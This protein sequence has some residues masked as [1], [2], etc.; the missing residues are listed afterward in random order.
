M[1]TPPRRTPHVAIV[2]ISLAAA[3]LAAASGHAR[4]QAEADDEDADDAPPPQQ[5]ARLRMQRQ[6]FANV[7][8]NIEQWVFNGK[9]GAMGRGREWFD[10]RLALALDEVDRVCHLSEAQKAKLRLAGRG[11]VK[12][13]YTLMEAI[14]RKL[15]QVKDDQNKVNQAFQE[16]QPL[17]ATVNAGPFG[18]TSIFAKAVGA[19]LTSEQA[20]QYAEAVRLRGLA[21][22]RARIELAVGAF[23]SALGLTAVQRQRFTEV[24]AAETKPPRRPGQ[25]DFYY[26]MYRASQ[27]PEDKLKPIFDDAQ[28]RAVGQQI[29]NYQ[30][31]GAWLQSNGSLDADEVTPM[32]AVEPEVEVNG[33]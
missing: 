28:W 20:A 16:I 9:A 26:I 30:G 31:W 17:Q 14:R 3:L 25:Y 27:I 2:A 33:Q 21:R 4:G 32:R 1:N 18:H 29:K 13:F 22:Y 23:D 10:E 12:R 8:Q 6:R 19:I 7:D 5:A 15:R 24:L 11:D